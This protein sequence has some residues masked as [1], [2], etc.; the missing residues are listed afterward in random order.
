MIGCESLCDVEHISV[1][2]GIATNY[3]EWL[4]LKNEPEKITEEL[5]TVSIEQGYPTKLSLKAIA[6]K[7]IAILT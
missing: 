4:F 6:D 2:Y 5:L 7:I 1:A 3:L